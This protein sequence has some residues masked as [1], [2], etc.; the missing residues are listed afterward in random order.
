MDHLTLFSCQHQLFPDRC[1]I[2]RSVKGPRG[3]WGVSQAVLNLAPK[4]K[5]LAVQNEMKQGFGVTRQERLL[6]DDIYVSRQT[7]LKSSWL[8]AAAVSAVLPLCQA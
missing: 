3:S 5:G 8:Q 7:L 1:G 6:R 4:E 2:A